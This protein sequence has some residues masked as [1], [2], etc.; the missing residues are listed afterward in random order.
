MLKTTLIILSFAISF[1]GCSNPPTE[2]YRIRP[3]K[4]TVHTDS[5]EVH[6]D[7]Q[8]KVYAGPVVSDDE[9]AR[10]TPRKKRE[11]I[12]LAVVKADVLHGKSHAEP[13]SNKKNQKKT[14]QP[15]IDNVPTDRVMPIH[16]NEDDSD[17]DKAAE[18]VQKNA[19][20]VAGRDTARQ[21]FQACNQNPVDTY[22]VGMYLDNIIGSGCVA[23]IK[24][25][26]WK[27]AIYKCIKDACSR[28]VERADNNQ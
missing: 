24:Y 22:C 3:T 11:I 7:F 10:M 27:A 9:Y 25:I 16:I 4:T 2:S 1:Y 8:F 18:I 21:C 6:T 28:M 13:R 12:N 5:L 26:S 23:E 20:T 19:I 14:I 17:P 15:S